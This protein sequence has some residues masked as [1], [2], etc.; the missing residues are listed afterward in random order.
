MEFL[1]RVREE[2][3]QLKEEKEYTFSFRLLVFFRST[4][5]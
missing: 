5:D 4:G 3:R 2:E 1:L